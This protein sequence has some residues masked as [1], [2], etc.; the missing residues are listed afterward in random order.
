MVFDRPFR[1]RYTRMDSSDDVWD[2]SSYNRWE[3]PDRGFRPRGSRS[4]GFR[5]N[6]DRGNRWDRGHS[7]GRSFHNRGYGGRSKGGDFV[8]TRMSTNNT[9]DTSKDGLFTVLSGMGLTTEQ[10]DIVLA[11]RQHPTTSTNTKS[12]SKTIDIHSICVDYAKIFN[13]QQ[14]WGKLPKTLSRS[15]DNFVGSIHLPKM[16]QAVADELDTATHEFGDRVC[17]VVR[18]HLVEKMRALISS[19]IHHGVED[20]RNI[21]DDVTRHISQ[22]FSPEFIEVCWQTMNDDLAVRL[23]GNKGPTDPNTAGNP[24]QTWS[25][26]NTAS[27]SNTDPTVVKAKTVTAP[28]YVNT[29]S[30]TYAS[31]IVSSCITGNGN[32]KIN[33]PSTSR[34]NLPVCGPTTVSSVSAGASVV[35]AEIHTAK[36]TLTS[37]DGAYENNKKTHKSSKNQDS[38]DCYQY[39]PSQNTIVYPNQNVARWKVN[40]VPVRC[41]TVILGDSNLKSWAQADRFQVLSYPGAH[42]LDIARIF[43]EWDAPPHVK[44]VVLAAGVNNLHKDDAQNRSEIEELLETAN[45]N[46]DVEV[47]VVGVAIAPTQDEVSKKRLQFI[48]SLLSDKFGDHFVPVKSSLTFVDNLHY[49]DGSAAALSNDIYHFLH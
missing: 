38:V 3:R 11:M 41:H 33:D 20:I 7:R 21:Q 24:V 15:L 30:K 29:T 16:D 47:W 14:N 40:K 49:D 46:K 19:L 22:R 26:T 8:P 44:T 18:F 6:Y 10:I 43:L 5:G 42:I 23:T 27:D 1:R 25:V 39:T 4:R 9:S 32:N 17:E 13:H 31:S 45:A 2:N 37:P 35:T 34:S 48:N 12:T 28:S 36:R